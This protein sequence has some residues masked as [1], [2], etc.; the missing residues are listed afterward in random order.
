MAWFKVTYNYGGTT[1]EAHINAFGVYD[2][3]NK[4]AQLSPTPQASDIHRIESCAEPGTGIM[5]QKVW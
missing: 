4:L 1:N 3:G 5:P 2:I